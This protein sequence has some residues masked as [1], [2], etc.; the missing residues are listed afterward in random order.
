MNTTAISLFQLVMCR[1]LR[2]SNWCKKRAGGWEERARSALNI[3]MENPV[4]SVRIKKERFIQVEI[5]RENG[6]TS[7]GITF[8]PLLSKLRNY[9][10]Y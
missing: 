8:S 5:F 3:C 10:A 4:I 7:G 2:Q 9:V 1:D 6:S